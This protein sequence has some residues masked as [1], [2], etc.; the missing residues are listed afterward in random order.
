MDVVESR[1]AA[2]GK[3]YNRIVWE[4]FKDFFGIPKIVLTLAAALLL[5]IILKASTYQEWTIIGLYLAL[6]G[7]TIYEMIKSQRQR[8]N[9]KKL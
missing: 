2:L 5:F 7:F 1:Q 3:K 8:I 6:F 4:H 9:K